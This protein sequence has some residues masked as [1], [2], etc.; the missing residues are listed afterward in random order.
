MNNYELTAIVEK[1]LASEPNYQLPP[2]FA[3]RVTVSVI[4]QGQWKTDLQ[5]YLL[6]TSIMIGILVAATG[7]YYLLD[8]S[9]LIRAVSFF[10]SNRTQVV[11]VI[12]LANFILFADKV[13][14]RLL[15]NRLKNN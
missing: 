6:L 4:R 11:W 8:K 2:D 5:E 12:F 3:R 1:S 14:L 15:F 13:L 7:S 10:E 9:I